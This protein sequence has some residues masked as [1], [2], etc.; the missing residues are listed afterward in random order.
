MA[1]FE[2][3]GDPVRRRILELLAD[4]P[5]TVNEI[6][7]EFDISR[8]AIS[9]H[10]RLLRDNALVRFEAEAQRRIYTLDPRGFEEAEAWL[11]RYR[12]MWSTQLDALAGTVEKRRQRDGKSG[13]SHK[14][15]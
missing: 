15:R 6:D 8:P 3:L 1:I 10:L 7:A 14:K 12:R 13:K 11:K 4:G 5:R 2:A 9:R